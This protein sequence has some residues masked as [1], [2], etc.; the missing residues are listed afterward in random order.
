MPNRTNKYTVS[1]KRPGTSTCF[2]PKPAIIKN[3]KQLQTS[4]VNAFFRRV[5]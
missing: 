5:I 1:R 4:K 2:G 3:S